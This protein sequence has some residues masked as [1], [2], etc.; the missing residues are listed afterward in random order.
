MGDDQRFQ[1]WASGVLGVVSL[2]L[3]LNLAR[4]Y[5][6]QWR[7]V[8]PARPAAHVAKSLKKNPHFARQANRAATDSA[9]AKPAA[10][11][12]T[13][14]KPS[15]TAIKPENNDVRQAMPAAS[16]RARPQK[17]EQAAASAARREALTAQ[18]AQIKPDVPPDSA[19]TAAAQAPAT[20][21][22]AAAPRVVEMQ[23]FG[24]V[25]KAD[26]SRQA[27]VSVGDRVLLVHEGETFDDHYRVLKISPT[28]VEVADL[29]A[30][31]TSGGSTSSPA[32][33]ANGAA[34]ALPGTA[35]EKPAVTAPGTSPAFAR[36]EAV[37]P[38]ASG[39]AKRNALLATSE[40]AQSA[41][42]MEFMRLRGPEAT[43]DNG[44]GPRSAD[45]TENSGSRR[46]NGLKQARTRAASDKTRDP[47]TTGA[48]GN[49]LAG[50]GQ[51]L[52]SR[53]APTAG[54]I[55]GHDKMSLPYGYLKLMIPVQPV[56]Q[57]TQKNKSDLQRP[58]SLGYVE[59]AGRKPEAIVAVGDEIHLVPDPSLVAAIPMT[60]PGE[61]SSW[62]PPPADSGRGVAGI[63]EVA[64]RGGGSSDLTD[65]PGLNA[66]P[67][68]TFKPYCFVEKADGS[69][70][71]FITLDGQAY[72]VFEGERF[73]DRYRVL[74]IS[75]VSVEVAEESLPQIGH[76]ASRALAVAENNS[77]SREPPRFARRSM[78]EALPW[79]EV[80]RSAAAL[81][82][83]AGLDEK[84]EV[85]EESKFLEGTR[86]EPTLPEAGPSTLVV[87]AFQ[88][89]ESPEERADPPFLDS[90]LAGPFWKERSD[91]AK[92]VLASP[93]PVPREAI[94]PTLPGI[95]SAAITPLP[96]NAGLAQ[97]LF[98]FSPTEMGRSPSS[99]SDPRWLLKQSELDLLPPQAMGHRE[100][101]S[102]TK[103]STPVLPVGS[104]GS[105]AS[106]EPSSGSDLHLHF[107]IGDNGCYFPR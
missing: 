85:L 98:D 43:G 87:S 16:D 6:T 24:Y 38:A 92:L 17:I 63:R 96:L 48:G 74:K 42:A 55:G 14:V 75:P 53:A 95:G 44:V 72:L 15:A 71:A 1:R 77:K 52:A 22:P 64:D 2:V 65:R 50:F 99:N 82:A 4:I 84:R 83:D 11:D 3:I 34:G 104:M 5:A 46:T 51:R 9:R 97:A 62:H 12:F 59:W 33:D 29:E 69:R 28:A 47:A 20:T 36:R 10:T 32:L 90:D 49:R 94:K 21:K 105:V 67:T 102:T 79:D 45:R 81:A 78:P 88:S 93:E 68:R 23:P 58:E 40:P 103:T 56:T 73:A 101:Q 60:E 26:G 31:V 7:T 91:G 80:V 57:L 13:Q 107:C 66:Q 35:P 37:A 54:L 100:G 86:S 41:R 70:E 106:F 18:T 30:P 8:F 89:R 27:A 61:G 25:E 19:A 39:R 76:P